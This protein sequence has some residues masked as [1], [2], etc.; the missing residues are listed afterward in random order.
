MYTCV[1]G[2]LWWP[3]V[4]LIY[5]FMYI[6]MVCISVNAHH[7]SAATAAAAAAL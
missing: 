5:I 1:E 6:C 2:T 7:T 4:D 3:A